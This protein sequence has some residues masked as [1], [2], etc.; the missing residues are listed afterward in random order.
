M[1][2]NGKVF[3]LWYCGI[4][5]CQVDVFSYGTKVLCLRMSYFR[6]VIYSCYQQAKVNLADKKE[7]YK[8]LYRNGMHN[9]DMEL[10]VPSFRSNQ[11]LAKVL[12]AFGLQAVVLHYGSGCGVR[13]LWL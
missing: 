9:F 7:T 3:L 5:Y 2:A 4:I 8:Y 11:Q 13:V 12:H 6:Y 10:L 1:F